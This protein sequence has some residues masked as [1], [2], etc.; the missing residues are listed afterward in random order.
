VQEWIVR[1]G[2]C[3][4][5]FTKAAELVKDGW[6]VAVSEATVRRQTERAGEAAARLQDE[7]A[8]ALER[9]LPEGKGAA[10]R[11]QVSVD[12]SYVQV[13]GGE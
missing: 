9:E 5:S 12:G 8:A 7:E 10:E 13:V 1:L 3:V 2:T 11:L 4:A 6:G